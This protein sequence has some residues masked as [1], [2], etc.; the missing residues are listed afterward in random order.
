MLPSDL[1]IALHNIDPTKCDMKTVMKATGICFSDRDGAYCWDFCFKVSYFFSWWYFFD[2]ISYKVW[3]FAVSSF[4][5][6]DSEIIK[7]LDF[8]RLLKESKLKVK[9]EIRNSN[10]NVTQPEIMFQLCTDQH[11]PWRCWRLSCSSWWSRRTSPCSWC[12]PS[13]SLCPSTPASW[14]SSWISSRGLLL[15]RYLRITPNLEHWT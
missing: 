4:F 15:N 7:N 14:A 12:A 11:I 1:L 2:I 5:L 9:L 8:Q 13:S 6:L 10:Q 3:R